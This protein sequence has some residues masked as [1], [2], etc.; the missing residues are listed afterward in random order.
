[1]KHSQSNRSVW[2]RDRYLSCLYLSV[3]FIHQPI[4]NN[5]I[6]DQRLNGEMLHADS[7]ESPPSFV[8]QHKDIRHIFDRELQMAAIKPAFQPA[9]ISGDGRSKSVDRNLRV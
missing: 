4:G 9:A 6:H 7:R 2:V 5:H 3:I 8:M 1:M